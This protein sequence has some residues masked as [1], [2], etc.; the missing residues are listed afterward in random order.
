MEW[1]IRE[2][3]HG[4]YT[5]EKGLQHDGGERVAGRLGFTM[6]AFIVYESAHF[7]TRK[8]AE[9]YIKRHIKKGEI[10]NE[11]ITD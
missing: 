3:S 9:N 2:C 5:V 4:G 8:Q 7:D 6:R 11:S 1:R 10:F